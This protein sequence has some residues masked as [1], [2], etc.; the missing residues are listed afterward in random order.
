M[1]P[2]V[3]PRRAGRGLY[4]FAIYS[5]HRCL[6][7]TVLIRFEDGVFINEIH[8]FEGAPP[9]SLAARSSIFGGA[10][11]AGVN[12]ILGGGGD[13]HGGADAPSAR[14]SRRPESG[15]ARKQTQRAIE[16]AEQ[17]AEEQYASRF[18]GE[19]KRSHHGPNE[20]LRAQQRKMARAEAK[21]AARR[22]TGLPDDEGEDD[23]GA[24]GGGLG[25]ADGGGGRDGEDDENEEERRAAVSNEETAEEAEAAMREED[26]E[27]WGEEDADGDDDGDEDDEED[28][29][30][31][32]EDVEDDEDDDDDEVG[33]PYDEDDA[34]DEKVKEEQ[35]K[36]SH[37]EQRGAQGGVT[38]G[39]HAEGRDEKDEEKLDEKPNE[40]PDENDDGDGDEINAQIY[41]KHGQVWMNARA[42]ARANPCEGT[43]KL[44]FNVDS[45]TWTVIAVGAR[46]RYLTVFSS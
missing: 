46:R 41:M 36:A 11:G 43:G 31:D 33:N 16:A 32:A 29:D 4:R 34:G 19:I 18:E 6:A 15:R 42:P 7:K 38:D 35:A 26:E 21:L 27:S 22:T 20:L 2:S 8:D 5:R 40:K 28:Y 37:D 25:D 23:P 44:M 1:H 9:R 14:A 45:Q 24:E 3:R 39:P 12:G 13:G 10:P 17:A 30:D